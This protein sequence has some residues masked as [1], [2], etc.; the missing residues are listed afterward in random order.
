MTLVV[1]FIGGPGLGKSVIAA[2]L[3]VE[4]KQKGYAVELA[5]E[6]AKDCTYEERHGAL[7]NQIYVFGKQHHRLHRLLGKVDVI[8]TDSCLLLSTIYKQEGLPNS[9]D[10]FVVDMYN[11]FNNLLFV[12][13]REF[14]YQEY[15]RGSLEEGQAEELDFMVRE[16]LS[17][18]NIDYT[19]INPRKDVDLCVERV[20]TLL[21][22]QG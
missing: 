6:Y 17:E 7:T 16:R 3:F 4:L 1:S 5:T 13:S 14:E 22:A 8:I 21:G 10:G 9:F 2:K 11:Q 18:H 20:I 15:G 12:L 19:V